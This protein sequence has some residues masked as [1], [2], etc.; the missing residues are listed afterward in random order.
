[1]RKPRETAEYR[2]ICKF[3]GAAVTVHQIADGLRLQEFIVLQYW[4]PEF[5]NQGVGKA[6][7]IRRHEGSLSTSV[8]W[9][10][11]FPGPEIPI[12]TQPSL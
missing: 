11:A 7:S 9:P 4:K 12:F 6:G 3:P 8:W 2:E 10:Q 1:M 5:Q